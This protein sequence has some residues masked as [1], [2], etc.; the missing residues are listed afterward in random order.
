M[1]KKAIP[2]QV[3]PVVRPRIPG[4][5]RFICEKQFYLGNAGDDFIGIVFHPRL[6]EWKFY[7]VMGNAQKGY[8]S[9]FSW[10]LRDFYGYGY[11]IKV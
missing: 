11:F 10:P 6:R 4:L 5:Y 8:A 7:G 1:K 2:A 3:K 9:G